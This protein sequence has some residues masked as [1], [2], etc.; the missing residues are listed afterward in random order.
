MKNGRK[1]IYS[2]IHLPKRISGDATCAYCKGYVIHHTPSL[3]S[4]HLSKLS[5]QYRMLWLAMKT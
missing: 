1:T 4:K 2:T 3:L 5:A